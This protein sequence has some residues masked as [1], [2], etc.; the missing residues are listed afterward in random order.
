MRCSVSG[1]VDGR[2]FFYV[3][4]RRDSESVLTA[5]GPPDD[6]RSRRPTWA[7]APLLVVTVAGAALR[8]WQYAADGSLWV[9]EL[10]L[11]RGILAA[12][13]RELL[14]SQLL[15]NQVAPKGF[16]LVEKL[17]ATAFGPSDYALRLFPLVCS[18]V[19]L[20]AFVR[21]SSRFLG[22]A[23]P[24]IASLLFAAAVPLVASGSQV[25]PYSADTCVAVLLLQL[26]CGL[27]TR[28]L[29]T[30][31]LA[32]TALG[33]ALLVWFSS[34]GVLLSAGLGAALL[35]SPGPNAARRD[36]RRPLVFVVACWCASSLAAAAATY[37]STSEATRDYMRWFWAGGF[38]PP[39]P[40]EFVN[41]LWPLERLGAVFGPGQTFAG[42]GYPAPVF[43][44]A[45]SLAGLVVLWLRDRSKALLLTLPLLFTFGAAVVRQY[46]FSD[47]LV[48]FLVPG[49]LLASAA[50][51]EGARGLLSSRS[52][53]LGAAAA[54]LLILPTLYTTAAT[55]PPFDNEPMKPVL[56]YLRGRRQPGDAVYVY[57]GAALAVTFYA[58]RYG[59]SRDAYAV[60]GC[61]RGDS[62]EYLRELDAFRGRPRV[63]VLLTHAGPA[64]KEREDVFAYL[65]AIG[66]ERERLVAEPRGVGRNLLPAEA[67]LYDL[68]DGER[69][70]DASAE[71]FPLKGP[72]APNRRLGCGEATQASL[73][74]DF[75]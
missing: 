74:D 54:A 57:Y 19:A 26:A 53:A 61:H 65:D 68:S 28:R 48:L 11:V 5:G 12:D 66:V 20:V 14:T 23:G 24:L 1:G 25:K 60:G 67:H 40:S 17:A 64:L 50:A 31:G 63:W 3:Y 2:A 27:S 37:A 44:A 35:I 18:L 22:G 52:R 70:D 8:V 49:L 7:T 34:P 71:T 59:L 4:T 55:P 16:L 21:L 42:L 30:R 73:P 47:R 46:P 45:L 62:R 38:A 41:T 9:D 15:H 39:S 75:R 10:A 51:V 6:A 29:T 43:Y 33:G 58:P 32:S 36:R 13:L 69:L 56:D 72:H